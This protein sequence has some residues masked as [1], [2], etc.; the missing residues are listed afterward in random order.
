MGGCASSVLLPLRGIGGACI[1]KRKVSVIALQ[2]DSTRYHPAGK[3]IHSVVTITRV[4]AKAPQSGWS[5][6][7]CTRLARSML[8]ANMSVSVRG[9]ERILDRKREK[10]STQTRALKE[11]GSTIASSRSII[12]LRTLRCKALPRPSKNAAV[13]YAACATPVFAAQLL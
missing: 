7:S 3:V 13:S 6:C 12:T 5:P 10:F 1:K 2:K 4:R 8:G 11:R 9:Y